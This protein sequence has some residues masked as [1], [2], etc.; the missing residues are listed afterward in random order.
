MPSI[1]LKT[2]DKSKTLVSWQLLEIHVF[3][4]QIIYTTRVLFSYEILK[5]HNMGV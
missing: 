3:N 4:L 2:G 1:R 5:K